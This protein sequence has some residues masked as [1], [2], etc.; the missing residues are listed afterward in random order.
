MVTEGEQFSQRGPLVSICPLLA[1]HGL[2]HHAIVG[3]LT[4]HQ[5]PFIFSRVALQCRREAAGMRIAQ[6][7]VDRPKQLLPVAR[8][9]V[10][11]LQLEDASGR[12]DGGPLELRRASLSPVAAFGT[13]TA[14]P[15]SSQ[16]RGTPLPRGQ[17]CRSRSTA[18]AG[19]AG[20]PKW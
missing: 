14:R 6:Q 8:P 11:V 7:R 16:Y 17:R 4:F 3:G 15:R 18:P 10:H 13:H 12:Q 20:L 5:D 1:F 9:I 19:P 2:Q